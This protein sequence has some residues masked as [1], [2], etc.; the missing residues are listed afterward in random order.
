MDLVVFG[1]I[2]IVALMVFVR[3]DRDR[4]YTASLPHG[5]C[6][7]RCGHSFGMEV[8]CGKRTNHFDGRYWYCSQ[9]PPQAR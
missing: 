2:L 7:A 9:H 4:G 3:M 8:T 1:L 6:E 5:T